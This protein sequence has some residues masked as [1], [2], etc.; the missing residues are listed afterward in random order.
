MIIGELPSLQVFEAK[1]PVVEKNYFNNGNDGCS[2]KWGGYIFSEFE[3]HANRWE[4][5]TYEADCYFIKLANIL[6]AVDGR[7][8]DDR[9]VYL[10]EVSKIKRSIENVLKYST[11]DSFSDKQAKEEDRKVL[12][13]FHD[14]LT[15]NENKDVYVICSVE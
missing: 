3:Q 2:F 5:Y 6:A 1:L 9:T 14:K 7:S 13:F 4:Y 10:Y 8:Y 12:S 15:Q 11:S